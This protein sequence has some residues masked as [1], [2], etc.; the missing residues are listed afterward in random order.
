MQDLAIV[1]I[2]EAHILER[3]GAVIDRQ[4]RGVRIVDDLRLGIHQIE[5][6][7]HV[8]QPLPDHAIDHAQQIERAEKL[9]QQPVDQHQIAHGQIAAAPQPDGVE[10]RAQHHRI[11]DEGL[12]DIEQAER[13]FGF[14][15]GARI[16]LHGVAVPVGLAL[17]RA[18]IFHRLVIQ[19]RIHAAADGARVQIVHFLPQMVAPVGH[20]AGE[21][22]IEPHHEGGG[23]DRSYAQLQ[24][25][26]HQHHRQLHHRGR[27]VEQQEIDHRVDGLGA[28]LHHLGDLARAAGQMIA[29]R[30]LVQMREGAAGQPMGG[31]LAHPLERYAAQRVERG[32]GKARQYIGADQQQDDGQGRLRIAG[33]AVDHRLIGKGHQQRAALGQQ[34]QRAGQREPPAQPR[35]VLGPEIGQEALQNRQDGRL[36]AGMLNIWWHGGGYRGAWVQGEGG[37][38]I[39]GDMVGAAPVRERPRSLFRRKSE[40]RARAALARLRNADHIR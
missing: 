28:A 10:H 18:E 27:D 14:L 17:F 6:G 33:H 21:P 2:G 36:R 11:G 16:A 4:R 22:Y 25:E 30:Q 38:P 35:R 19:Q 34:H 37:Q 9:H 7:G 24:V 3:H 31:G 1:I 5:H 20:L 8:D 15:G 23:D 13:I 32:A 26:H 40:S 12:A 39:W 29:Q